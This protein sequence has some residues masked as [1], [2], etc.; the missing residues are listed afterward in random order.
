[1]LCAE[2]WRSD[3]WQNVCSLPSAGG[4]RLGK[5]RN[6][7]RVLTSGHSAKSIIFAE[8]G[9]RGTRQIYKFFL[10]T[11]VFSLPDPGWEAS[12]NSFTSLHSY[13]DASNKLI[14]HKFYK[15]LTTKLI[16]NAK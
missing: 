5:E 15:S 11:L 3:A 12:H 4:M 7:C 16:S 2:G 14:D 13:T 6:L 1:M 8:S 9:V 10:K